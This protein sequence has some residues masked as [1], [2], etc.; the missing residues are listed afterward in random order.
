MDRRSFKDKKTSDLKIGKI[1]IETKA[2]GLSFEK[3]AEL[4]KAINL[5]L[6]SRGEDD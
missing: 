4:I 1:F 6:Q 5:E 3:R 2:E